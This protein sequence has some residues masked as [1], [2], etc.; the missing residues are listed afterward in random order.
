MEIIYVK[1]HKQDSEKL[2]SHGFFHTCNLDFKQ[3]DM[4]IG[5]DCLR[6]GKEPERRGLE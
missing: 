3:K 1:Q 4:K 6:N 2:M 5:R